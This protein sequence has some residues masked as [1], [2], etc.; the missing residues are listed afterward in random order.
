MYV[1]IYLASEAYS[2]SSPTSIIINFFPSFKY[3]ILLNRKQNTDSMCHFLCVLYLQ[4]TLGHEFGAGAACLKCKDKC[5]GFE[6]HFWRFEQFL[7]TSSQFHKFPFLCFLCPN[8]WLKSESLLSWA[9]LWTLQYDF[10]LTKINK[11]KIVFS[12]VQSTNTIF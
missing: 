8:C 4:V 11:Q 12:K 3:R 2:D 7:C 10:S 5:E 9:K 6:L 1:Y